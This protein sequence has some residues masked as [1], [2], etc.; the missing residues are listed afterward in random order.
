M[1]G[2]LPPYCIVANFLDEEAV[3]N[4][5]THA[6]RREADFVPTQVGP[7][8]QG[9]INP[10]TRVSLGLRD[11]KAFRPVLK[12]GIYGLLPSFV[13]ELRLSPIEASKLEL[14]LVAHNDG[15]YYKRHIDTATSN[16]RETLRVLSGVYYFFRQPKAFTGGALRIHEIGGDRFE[17]IEPVNNALLVFPSWAPHEVLPVSVPSRA[18]KDSRFAINC[19]VHVAKPPTA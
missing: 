14:E 13:S 8:D 18:F 17:D 6:E 9:R 2:I 5:L 15:A 19:W 11:L 3:R 10:K 1:A 12:R 4:L 16:Q 7:A